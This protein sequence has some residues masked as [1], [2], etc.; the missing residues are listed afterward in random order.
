MAIK[1]GK[2]TFVSTFSDLNM[3]LW[4]IYHLTIPDFSFRAWKAKKI[5]THRFAQGFLII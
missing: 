1:R 2:C 5:P 3:N 4:D